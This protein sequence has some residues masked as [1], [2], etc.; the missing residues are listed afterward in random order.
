MS[1]ASRRAMDTKKRSLHCMACGQDTPT[2]AASR[3]ANTVHTLCLCPLPSYYV[4]PEKS[5]FSPDFSTV[6][7][8][9][10]HRARSVICPWPRVLSAPS[11]AAFPG[12][13]QHAASLRTS[14]SSSKTTSGANGDLQPHMVCSAIVEL[15]IHTKCRF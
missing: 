11:L 10:P 15:A 4:A 2:P 6:L 8:L 1:I 9:N 7:L 5:S 14:S 12:V 13:S 3:Q